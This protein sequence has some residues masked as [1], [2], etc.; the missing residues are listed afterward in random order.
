[1]NSAV[2][3]SIAILAAAPLLAATKP[4]AKAPARA[5]VQQ[6][7]PPKTVYWL[8]AATASGFTMG[9]RS[10]STGDMMRMAMGGGMDQVQKDLKL[11]LGSK[12]PPSGPPA[13][14]HAIPPAMNMGPA[15]ALKTPRP[16]ATANT[17]REPEDFERPKGQILLFWGC[18]E[19]ARPGQPVVI[20][21][22]KMAAGQI[23]PGLFGGER[24]RIARPPMTSTW[25]T[26]GGWPNEDRASKQAVPADASLLGPHKVTGNYS[27]PIDFTLTQDWMA[28]LAMQQSKLPSGALALSWNRVPG[29]TSHFA[30]MFGGGG[31]KKP[32]SA[33]IVFWSSSDVQTFI[34]GLSDFIAPAEAARLVGT[35]QLMPAEQTN[36]AI[37]KEAMAASQGGLISLVAHGP[38]QNF[39]YP[40]RPTNPKVPWVQ[41][42]TVKAR[43]ASRTGGIA[44]MDMAAMGGGSSGKGKRG[45]P[46]CQPS[47]SGMAGEALG[48]AI[49]GALGGMFGKKK[50]TDCE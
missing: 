17:P 21:F 48:G 7:V 1:M 38:E 13:A 50:K 28:D 46:A 49:G 4:P 8:S 40:P 33:T 12:V 5:P 44:G 41:D 6:V 27:S 9:S 43:F 39:V 42:W 22:E 16:V 3:V 14:S 47:T 31:G 19:T 32:D 2:R 30:Q 18:G 24:V 34:S 25:P 23:P 15:L 20:D 37:P 45:K 11:D 35:K 10:P 26:Y 29:A 36:C